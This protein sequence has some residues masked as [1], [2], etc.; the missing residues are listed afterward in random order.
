MKSVKILPVVVLLFVIL[1]INT[2]KKDDDPTSNS[3]DQTIEESFI[4]D[5][6][7]IPPIVAC[8]NGAKIYIPNAFSPN[9]N[10]FN[11]FF[12]PIGLDGIEEIISF[13]IYNETGNLIFENNNFRTGDPGEGWDGTLPDGNMQDGIYTYI[14][15]IANLLDE[16]TEFEGAVCCRTTLPLV[17]VENEAHLAWGTQHDGNGGL[18]FS[19]PSYEDCE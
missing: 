16:V 14:I 1:F 12:Y 10:G 3:G 7:I 6:G 4:A 18:D 5:C 11:D 2:C 8:L 13:K 19:L 15:S 9:F 17:C